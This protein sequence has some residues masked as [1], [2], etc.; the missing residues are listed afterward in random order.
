M[1]CKHKKIYYWR[2]RDKERQREREMEEKEEKHLFI[3]FILFDCVVYII[4]L[5]CI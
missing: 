4:L 2:E 5:S 3:Y 1:G